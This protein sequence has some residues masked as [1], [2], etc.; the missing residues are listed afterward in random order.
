MLEGVGKLQDPAAELGHLG[1]GPPES[2]IPAA[3]LL[4]PLPVR[5]GDVGASCRPLLAAIERRH[6]VVLPPC[7]TAGG[8]AAAAGLQHVA[9]PDHGAPFVEQLIKVA[10]SL[11]IGLADGLAEARGMRVVGHGI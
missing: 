10:G 2:P 5:K 9:A 3:E 8:L 6:A 1:P 4:H 11:S 7:T